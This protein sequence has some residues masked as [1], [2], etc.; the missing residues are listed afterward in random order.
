[1][2]ET[3]NIL[4][5]P[6]FP[7][8]MI[9]SQLHLE[10]YI[11]FIDSRPIRN[12]IKFKTAYHH[13]IPKSLGGSNLKLNKVYLTHREHYIAHL[14]LWKAF[15]GEMAFTFHMMYNFKKEKYDAD[16]SSK[17]YAKLR[18]D[19]YKIKKRF[20]NNGVI[21]KK[22]GIAS[23]IEEGFVEGK[24]KTGKWPKE[25]KERSRKTK[26]RNGTSNGRKGP[27][28]K[29]KID[30][31]KLTMKK[32]GTRSGYTG[33]WSKERLVKDKATRLKNESSYG[34]KMKKWTDEALKKAHKTR[35]LNNTK[36]GVKKGSYKWI[37]NEI[38]N[39]YIKIDRIIPIGWRRGMARKKV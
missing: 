32:N 5:Y 33:K 6:N 36:T 35:S 13:K 26:D 14:I 8:E 28:S 21:N 16:L 23:P 30:R 31:K 24:L 15:G 38:E 11:K 17:Q 1:M 25:R 19:M 18:E 27:W 29:E 7:K 2:K 20:I 9:K 10:R 22:I 12:K 3:K 34:N 39:K 4:I 37:T